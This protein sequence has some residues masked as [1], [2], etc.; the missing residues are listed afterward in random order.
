MSKK[1]QKT[2]CTHKKYPGFTE[3]LIEKKYKIVIQ[4]KSN[5]TVENSNSIQL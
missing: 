5:I 1:K 4:Q 2:G 3:L